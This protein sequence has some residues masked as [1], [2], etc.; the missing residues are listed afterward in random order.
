MAIE[1]KLD[2]IGPVS[3]IS[4]G[5]EGGLVTISDTRG[6]KVKAE[7][8]ISANTLPNLTL[9]VKRVLSKTQLLVGEKG[10]IQ[11]RANIQ[12][13]T[14][15]LGATIRQPEQDRP[16]IPT[17]QH[18]R[19]VFA[20]EPILAKRTILVDEYGNYYNEENPLPINVELVADN[21]VVNSDLDAFS[22]N[23]DSA[24]S[25]GSEDGTKNGIKHVIKI[26]DD[27]NLR[28]KDEEANTHLSNI[29]NSLN[30]PL[31]IQQPV[32]TA[33]TSDGNPTSPVFTN[34]NNIKNQILATHD[35]QQNITY[36]DFGTKNQRI[37]QI[38]YTSPTFPGVTASKVISYTLVSN[39][40]RR[41][42]INWI[43]S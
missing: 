34:I 37:T 6:F 40:Y 39:K 5:T 15:A 25:V 24:L 2:N 31:T 16:G 10:K 26:G 17:E 19:A 21:V 18:E 36:A 7:V 35:R 9:E 8:V 29:A 38:D 42:S 41:D 33:G 4:N 13:Y 3:F 43:I 22:T 32:I 1:R 30:Q 23:P 27:L 11:Q 12:A 20:E 28:V 14:V